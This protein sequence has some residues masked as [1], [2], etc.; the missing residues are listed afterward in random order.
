MGC[1]GFLSLCC[2]QS[3][4]IEGF[5][6]PPVPAGS[7]PPPPGRGWA[8]GEAQLPGS[9]GRKKPW[10]RA[11]SCAGEGARMGA[12][13]RPG[14]RVGE[15]RSGP[16]A[17]GVRCRGLGG[18]RPVG[19]RADPAARRRGAADRAGGAHGHGQPRGPLEEPALQRPR[20]P[21]GAADPRALRR[22]LL[23]PHLQQVLPAPRRLLRPP[24]LRPVRQ[25]GLHGRLDG[26]GVP[27]RCGRAAGARARG[28][29]TG[30]RGMA[31]VEV[32]PPP[33]PQQALRP[34]LLQPCASRAATCCMGAAPC[35]GSAG[36]CPPPPPSPP[37]AQTAAHTHVHTLHRVGLP[38][39]GCCVGPQGGWLGQSLPRGAG[40]GTKCPLHMRVRS[41][42]TQE[43]RGSGSQITGRSWRGWGRTPQGR[44][45]PG[46][47]ELGEKEGGRTRAAASG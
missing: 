38:C 12:G 16:S 4:S 13:R 28:R 19:G 37:D 29:P 39:E 22:E 8:G 18:P 47:L 7:R 32:L 41:T 20:G 10:F 36:E 40:L 35:L 25:Q 2:G 46:G 15:P 30:G 45:A 14:A 23:Q 33:P 1:R 26:Q 11:G 27:A 34:L 42:G 31:A 44:G 6:G 9:W 5:T 24:H 43:Q 17:V 3:Q 21:P